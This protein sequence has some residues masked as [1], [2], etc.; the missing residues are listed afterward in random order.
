MET[1]AARDKS[2][3]PIEDKRNQ[4]NKNEFQAAVRWSSFSWQLVKARLKRH[5]VYSKHRT[6]NRNA[7]S[8]RERSTLSDRKVDK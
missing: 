5:H 8:K 1:F 7:D 3:L 4:R 2:L 6:H